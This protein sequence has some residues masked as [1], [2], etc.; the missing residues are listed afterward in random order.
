LL[1]CPSSW[2]KPCYQTLL[3]EYW[4]CRWKCRHAQ[5]FNFNL[6]FWH[7]CW[8]L[9]LFCLEK[10]A[11]INI[12]ISAPVHLPTLV[13]Q[14]HLVPVKLPQLPTCRNPLGSLCPISHMDGHLFSPRSTMNSPPCVWGPRRH[15]YSFHPAIGLQFLY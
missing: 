3:I 14:L 10:H 4:I 9:L 13:A 6:P 7:N 5:M 2:N 12:L 15:T 11:L 1:P 8:T